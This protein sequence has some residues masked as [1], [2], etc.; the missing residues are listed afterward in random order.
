MYTSFIAKNASGT[1]VPLVLS[2]PLTVPGIPTM[3]PLP[4]PSG[5]TQVDGYTPQTDQ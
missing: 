1:A 2:Q 5:T 4:A 3:T